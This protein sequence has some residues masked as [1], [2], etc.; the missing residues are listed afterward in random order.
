MKRLV[1]ALLLAA[2]CLSGCV[3]LDLV[4]L[5]VVAAQNSVSD[6]VPTDE[7]VLPDKLETAIPADYKPFVYRSGQDCIY[8]AI[9]VPYDRTWPEEVQQEGNTITLPPE[10][11]KIAGYIAVIYKKECPQKE[12]EP[13]LRAGKQGTERKGSIFDFSD[14]AKKTVM[15][16]GNGGSVGRALDSRDMLI[17]DKEQ[18]QWWPQVVAR[19]TRLAQ[20]DAVV[21]EA[22]A[23][24]R[25][26]FIRSVPDQ[27]DAINA[28]VD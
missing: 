24:S 7:T 2:S 5:A 8:S 28:A 6:L 4:Y 1:L 26:L 13:M 16:A 18:P 11:G 3:G 19:M 9:M 15:R 17:A 23:Y 12:A 14:E 25:E 21:K 10:P 22:L 20:T 27:T